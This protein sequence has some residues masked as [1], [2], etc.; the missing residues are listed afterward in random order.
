MTEPKIT[1]YG[2][3]WCGDCFRARHF[4]NRHAIDYRWVDIDKDRAGEELVLRINK[5]MRS[6]PTIIFEDGSIL[7]EPSNAA[8]SEKLSI[9]QK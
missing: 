8:L 9:G 1:I 6:V 7:V 4:L 3:W 2:T 5:G